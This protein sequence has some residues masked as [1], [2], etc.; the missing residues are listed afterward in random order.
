MVKRIKAAYKLLRPD[1]RPPSRKQPQS[2][3]YDFHCVAEPD[4]EVDRKTNTRYYDLRPGEGRLF[5]TGLAIALEE[6]HALLLWDRSGLA[7]FRDLHRLAGVID[8]DYRGELLV[9]LVNMSR[10][11]IIGWLLRALNLGG[12][13]GVCRI[14]E[15]DR[16]VQ[17]IIA[18]R[19]DA[20]WGVGVDE[21]PTGLRGAAGFGSTGA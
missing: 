1:A 7:A 13:G 16:I 20:D 12:G 15:G 18:E 21:L 9:K 4:W 3:G 14:Y 5:H 11:G 10:P 2:T 19:I 8:E 17:G 6:G